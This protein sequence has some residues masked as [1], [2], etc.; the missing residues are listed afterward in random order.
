MDFYVFTYVNPWISISYFQNNFTAH[1]KWQ[2]I[3]L[4]SPEISED[5]N[6]SSD[7]EDAGFERIP[8]N[9][10]ESNFDDESDFGEQDDA[11][12][13]DHSDDEDENDTIGEASSSE[14]QAGPSKQPVSSKLG[15]APL[16]R[17]RRT[18][19]MQETVTF[20]GENLPDQPG[21]IQISFRI[22]QLNVW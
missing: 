17:C 2:T 18:D 7:D 13:S 20:T 6:D 9:V 22:F 5:E 4:P 16:Y 19:P 8:T 3:V 15:K 1:L 12:A 21:I 10:K 11:I 14:E